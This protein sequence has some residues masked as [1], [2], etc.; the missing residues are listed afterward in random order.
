MKFGILE[1]EQCDGYNEETLLR[2]LSGLSDIFGS[3]SGLCRVRSCVIEVKEGCL[4]VNLPHIKSPC[5]S[6]TVR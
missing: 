3:E 6:V 2:R 5:T 4:V 1:V